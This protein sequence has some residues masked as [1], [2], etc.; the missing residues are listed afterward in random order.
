M[1]TAIT[2]KQDIKS[3][4]NS[5]SMREQFARALPKHLHV[6]RFIRIAI[7]ALTRTPKLQ[8]CT[9]A[10]LMKCLL[11]L[12]A[13]GLE[14]DGRRA[15]LIPF[16]N[17]KQG[18]VECTLIVDYKGLIDLV[19]RDPNVVDVQAYTVREKDKIMIHNGVPEH[20]FNPIE[21]RGE[22]KAVYSKIVWA[23]GVTTYGEPMPWKEAES[24]RNRSK[25]WSAWVQYK[26]EGPWNTDPVEMWK[27]T[28]IRRD[29]KMWPLSPEIREAVERDDDQFTNEQ[30]RDVTPKAPSF[31]LPETPAE[32]EVE[33]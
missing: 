6:D 30:M 8:E 27:K 22:V 5:D 17:K 25:A 15:H 16:E 28:V 19:R 26:K 14:P 9:P 11:D 3:L 21:D 31:I 18:T 12:S 32:T 24:V 1:T 33:Q 10:S 2:Q 4:I 29:S 20:F 23:N 13:L 7:T